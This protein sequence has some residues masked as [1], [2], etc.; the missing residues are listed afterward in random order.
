MPKRVENKLRKQ[1]SKKG[2]K[3]ERLDHA[4]YG[5]LNKMG[6]MKGSKITAKGKKAE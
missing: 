4:V 2:L 5:T 1:F 3:G 6:L